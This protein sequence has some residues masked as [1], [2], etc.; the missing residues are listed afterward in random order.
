MM[1]ETL[2]TPVDM[3]VAH[4]QSVS[5]ENDA[6]PFLGLFISLLKIVPKV[7]KLAGRDFLITVDRSRS[8]MRV[9]FGS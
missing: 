8:K 3:N 9:W 4:E 7:L 1:Q 2:T 6:E 5:F